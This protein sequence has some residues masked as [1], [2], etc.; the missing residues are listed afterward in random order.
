M[1]ARLS[2]RPHDKRLARVAVMLSSR[3]RP[4]AGSLTLGRRESNRR[5]SIPPLSNFV[6]AGLLG[7]RENPRKW[8]FA[9]LE[10]QAT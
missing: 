2:E 5:S 1:P 6:A 4:R 7:L 9:E 3:P 8:C 10:H